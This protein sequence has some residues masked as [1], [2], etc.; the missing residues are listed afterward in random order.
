MFDFHPDQLNFADFMDG[1]EPSFPLKTS[2]MTSPGSATSAMQEMSTITTPIHAHPAAHEDWP[3]FACNPTSVELSSWKNTRWYLDTL[4]TAL[5]NG[6]SWG[7]APLTNPATFDNAS[8]NETIFGELINNSTRDKLLVVT[9]GLIQK[10]TAHTRHAL[11]N[12]TYPVTSAQD[13]D[14]ESFVPIPPAEVLDRYLRVYWSRFEPYYGFATTVDLHPSRMLDASAGKSS[15]LLLLSMVAHG[16]LAG[17]YAD[18]CLSSTLTEACH[19]S[20]RELMTGEDSQ[21]LR[22]TEALRV[23]L[24]MLCLTAWSGDAWHMNVMSSFRWLFF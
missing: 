12:S 8:S 23:A 6:G 7:N 2:E 11:S 17:S 5:K 20:F 1:V 3:A 4:K 22:D 14:H 24:S 9:Q 16:A 15:S 19:F 21:R 18:W 10:A 13:I